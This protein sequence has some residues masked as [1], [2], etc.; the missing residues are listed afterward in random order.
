M[1][2][3]M[4]DVVNEYA[5]RLGQYESTQ[6]C[7]SAA[8]DCESWLLSKDI[9]VGKIVGILTSEQGEPITFRNSDKPLPTRQFMCS[10]CYS[11]TRD[12]IWVLEDEFD[13]KRVVVGTPH[14]LV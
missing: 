12:C 1:A 6:S 10:M 14:Q 13:D 5:A 11:L 9:P 3:T 4:Q 2:G 8:A 7:K